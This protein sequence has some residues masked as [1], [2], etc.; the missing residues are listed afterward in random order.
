MADLR[1]KPDRIHDG[2]CF[3]IDHALLGIS[4]R[5]SSREVGEK[6]DHNDQAGVLSGLR[7]L[8]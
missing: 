7:S 1:L 3:L 8:E 6:P 5:R 2:K 4:L